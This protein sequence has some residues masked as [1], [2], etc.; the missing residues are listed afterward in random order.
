MN[1]NDTHVLLLLKRAVYGPYIS[2]TDVSVSDTYI[3]LLPDEAVPLVM[4]ARRSPVR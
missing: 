4:S 1:L 2:L 3:L